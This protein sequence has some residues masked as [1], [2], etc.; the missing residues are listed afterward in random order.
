MDLP[1]LLM[2]SAP[3][4]RAALH[5]WQCA[6]FLAL[7]VVF[8]A[9]SLELCFDRDCS[10]GLAVMTHGGIRLEFLMEV[11]SVEDLVQWLSQG[12]L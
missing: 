5:G 8:R 12:S 9:K 7:V 6:C 11:F 1:H 3:V 4:E 2:G 10:R